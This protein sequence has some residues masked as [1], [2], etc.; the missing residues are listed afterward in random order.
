[1]PCLG[2]T[3]AQNN[4]CKPKV[5]NELKSC[6]KIISLLLLVISCMDI[7]YAARCKYRLV[8]EWVQVTSP[9]E[10]MTSAF[11]Y[12]Y[13]FPTRNFFQGIALLINLVLLSV[14]LIYLAN[15]NR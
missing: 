15:E 2:L 3:Y 14:I 11:T 9:A 8:G 7:T 12:R 1:M 10:L 4:S 13:L 5:K 6:F